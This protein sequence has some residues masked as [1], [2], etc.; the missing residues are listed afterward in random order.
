MRIQSCVY[1]NNV[2]ERDHRRVK[3]RVQT[4]LVFR[5]SEMHTLELRVSSSRRKSKRDRMTCGVGAEFRRV[6]RK[7]GNATLAACRFDKHPTTSDD[8]IAPSLK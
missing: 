1:F 7:F 6:L 5:D 2:V 8:R 4:M 3:S